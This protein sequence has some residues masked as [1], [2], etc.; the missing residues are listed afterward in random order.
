MSHR[1]GHDTYLAGY[2][3]LD[4]A[5]WRCWHCQAHVWLDYQTAPLTEPPKETPPNE[6]RNK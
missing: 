5:I 3:E 6:K 4:R 2:D 1:C